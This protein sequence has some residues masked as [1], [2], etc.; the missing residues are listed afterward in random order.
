LGHTAATLEL[1]DGFR[2]LGAAGAASTAALKNARP[3]KFGYI[4]QFVGS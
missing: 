4:L 2:D 1:L 3:K